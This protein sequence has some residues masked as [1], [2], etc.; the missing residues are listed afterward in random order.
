MLLYHGT[1]RKQSWKIKR[2]GFKQFNGLFGNGVY[3]TSSLEGALI[4]G[5]YIISVE[6][7]H[8]TISF[9]SF[10]QWQARYPEEESWAEIML[11]DQCPGIAIEYESGEIEVCMYDAKLIRIVN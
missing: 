9:Y 11:H 8:E 2:D 6:V 3:F 10:L 7:P 1:S 4:F 5:D